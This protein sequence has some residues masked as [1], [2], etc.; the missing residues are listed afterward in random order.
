MLDKERR[1]KMKKNSDIH[2]KLETEY[3]E[4]L[5]RQAE[6]E[7]IPISTLCRKRIKE[8]HSFIKIEFL[9]NELNKKLVHSTK[10][11]TGGVKW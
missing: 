7:G 5:K 10:F 9:L 6:E 11:Q 2:I 1:L 4:K 3:Y 8:E